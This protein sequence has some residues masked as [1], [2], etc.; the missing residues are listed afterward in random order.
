[1]TNP[2]MKPNLMGRTNGHQVC[3]LEPGSNEWVERGEYAS[4]ESRSFADSSARVWEKRGHKV[5]IYEISRT[6]GRLVYET[7]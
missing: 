7:E 6:S 3:T 5:R 4:E 2:R 1:M